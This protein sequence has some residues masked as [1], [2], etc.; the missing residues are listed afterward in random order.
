MTSLPRRLTLL[1]S[2]AIVISNMIGVGIFG[3]TGFLAGDLGRPVWVL[4]AWVAGAVVAMAGCL[5][6]A[7]LGINLPRS[8]GE[9]VYIRE[10]WGPLWGFLSG[11]ISFFAGFSAPIA[12]GALLFAEYLSHFFPALTTSRQS[13]GTVPLMGYLQLGWPQFVALAVIAVFAV[14]NILGVELAARV[15]NALTAIKILV[16]SSFIV[17]AFS[18]GN[19]H[20]ENLREATERTSAHGLAVQFAISLIFVMYAYSGWNAATYVAEEIRQPERTLPRALILGTSLVAGLYLALNVAFLYALSLGS[21][22][23]VLSVGATTATALFGKGVGGLFTAIMAACILS[24]V[25]A[26]VIVGPRVYYAMAADGCFFRDAARVSVRWQTPSRAIFY[27]ALAAGVMVVT[28]SFVGLAYYI[29]GALVLFAALATAGDMR[30]RRRA[31]WK[32]LPALDLAFPLIP[33]VFIL[34]SLW[35]LAYAFW[36]KPAVA[37]ACALTLGTGAVIYGWKFRGVPKTNLDP[38]K[39]AN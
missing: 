34:A 37:A 30:L 25:S 4:A 39:T 22:K 1:S 9:Y 14:I 8:G 11:W 28:A 10:A 35:M 29:G 33:A 23:G 12:A 15:Q 24:S 21:L 20:W 38:S 5:S 6:Y 31:G 19:G 32:R 27:Q 17:L 3:A 18:I 7:E 36:S 26:M 16:L 13:S 2:A